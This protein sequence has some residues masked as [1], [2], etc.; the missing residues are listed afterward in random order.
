MPSNL[1]FIDVKHYKHFGKLLIIKLCKGAVWVTH[2]LS[3]THIVKSCSSWE[4]LIWTNN[5]RGNAISKQRKQRKKGRDDSFFF[6]V[7]C[8]VRQLLYTQKR[9]YKRNSQSCCPYMTHTDSPSLYHQL[10]LPHQKN[11]SD[12]RTETCHLWFTHHVKTETTIIYHMKKHLLWVDV[13]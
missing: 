10:F 6:C 4:G 12:C 8:T 3:I 7:V 1:R 5:M 11:F 13:P 9:F 2:T